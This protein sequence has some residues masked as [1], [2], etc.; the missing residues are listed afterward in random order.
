MLAIR[1]VDVRLVG[2]SFGGGTAAKN[3][4]HCFMDTVMSF[5][6]A[7]GVGFFG[8]V[9]SGMQCPD[10]ICLL[11]VDVEPFH[12]TLQCQ[13]PTNDLPNFVRLNG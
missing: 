6:G 7:S 12:I 1:R 13:I 2:D 3:L 9:I 8:F 11:F 5:I 10:V 4:L